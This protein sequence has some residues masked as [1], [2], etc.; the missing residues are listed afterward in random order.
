[1]FTWMGDTL[2]HDQNTKKTKT[3]KSNSLF[4]PTAVRQDIF[5]YRVPFER[6]NTVVVVTPPQRMME[7]LA[8]EVSMDPVYGRP[9]DAQETLYRVHVTRRAGITI[10]VGS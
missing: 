2:T 4:V 10:R 1:M 8:V 6:S 3:V 9:C 7:I 5:T